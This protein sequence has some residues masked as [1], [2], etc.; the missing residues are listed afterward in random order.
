MSVTGVKEFDADELCIGMD[1][2]NNLWQWGI[3]TYDQ[4]YMETNTAL[5]PVR[6]GGLKN[7]EK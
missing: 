7:I 3:S 1:S 4:K 2:D 6:I 5:E